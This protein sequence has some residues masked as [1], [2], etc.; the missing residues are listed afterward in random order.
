MR[1]DSEAPS[2]EVFVPGT[3]RAL[4][5]DPATRGESIRRHAAETGQGAGAELA[6]ARRQM[7]ARLEHVAEEAAGT[8]ASLGFV[9]STV[10]NGKLASASLIVALIDATDGGD[11]SAPPSAQAIAEGLQLRLGGEVG[12]LTAGPALRVRR[13]Q[14]VHDWIEHPS[15]VEVVQWYVP[16]EGGQRLAVLTFSTPN[17]ELAEQFGEVFDAIAGS[18]RWTA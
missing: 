4:D 2:V 10:A 5:L 17:V 6:E 8:G 11:G 13:R 9:F 12:D 18:L 15:E 7:Q 1:S 3:W 16:H 14:E